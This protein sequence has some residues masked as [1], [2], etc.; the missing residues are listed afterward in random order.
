VIASPDA[1]LAV[2]AQR[3]AAHLVSAPAVAQLIHVRAAM[4]LSEDALPLTDR[5]VQRLTEPR[6]LCDKLDAFVRLFDDQREPI[7]AADAGARVDQF[8]DDCRRLDRALSSIST[9]YLRADPRG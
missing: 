7:F 6:A 1:V 4:I 8:L 3:R 2:Y 5:Y 9:R